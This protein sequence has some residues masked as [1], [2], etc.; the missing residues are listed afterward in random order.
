MWDCLGADT[1]RA[2]GVFHAPGAI[3][4]TGPA[5]GGRN[6]GMFVKQ[7][8]VFLENN[9]GTLAKVTRLLSDHGLDLIALSIADTRDFGILRGIVS[10]TE[11]AREVLKD[12][13]YT[14]RLTDVLAVCVPDLPG[15]LSAVLSLL[16]DENISV[17][18]LY[19]FVRSAGTTGATGKH[20]LIILRVE[21]PERARDVLL[22]HDVKLMDDGQVRAL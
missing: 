14:V 11:K 22:A 21:E 5:A 2:G 13:G 8:S 6:D 17:E 4:R 15:G 9:K 10:D 19:S 20:A 3:S 12:A 1:S 7:I 16:D 18:Y